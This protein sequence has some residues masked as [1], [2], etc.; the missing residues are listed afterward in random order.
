MTPVPPGPNITA[1]PGPPL[2]PTVPPAADC[3][4]FAIAFA[5]ALAHGE[6]PGH[7][8]FRIRSK[9][10]KATSAEVSAEGGDDTTPTE[11]ESA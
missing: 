1:V 5:S 8:L 3:S 7:C 9:Q 4:L 2:L 6:Q 11:E 10:G